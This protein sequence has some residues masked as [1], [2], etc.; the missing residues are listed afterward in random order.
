MAGA[1]GRARARA[2]TAAAPGAARAPEASGPEPRAPDPAEAPAAP[3]GEDV[4]PEDEAAEQEA[5]DGPE[6]EPEPELEPDP[7][8]IPAAE[9]NGAEPRRRRW[10][11]RGRREDEAE[12]VSSQPRHVRVL[13]ADAGSATPGQRLLDPWEEDFDL[14]IED[15]PEGD[16]T[17]E[18]PAPQSQ[19]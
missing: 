6:P 18:E 15:E 11:Q 1:C 8:L 19:A 7:E 17:R 2:L 16:G 5:A 9:V 13:P 12:D 3:L 14:S 10:W 4:E